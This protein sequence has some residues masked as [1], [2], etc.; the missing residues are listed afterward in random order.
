MR[1]KVREKIYPPRGFYNIGMYIYIY[2]AQGAKGARNSS[3]HRVVDIYKVNMYVSLTPSFSCLLSVLAWIYW[4]NRKEVSC[5]F[6]SSFFFLKIISLPELFFPI[7]I[8]GC[9]KSEK[10]SSHGNFRVI[11]FRM[12]LERLLRNLV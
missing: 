7:I 1:P 11:F 2:Q 3:A 8:C 5:F 4:G 10:A 12:I 6:A 9:F